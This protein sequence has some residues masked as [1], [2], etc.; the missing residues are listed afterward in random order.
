MIQEKIIDLLNSMTLDEKIGQLIQITPQLYYD[1]TS[2]TAETGPIEKLG[3]SEEHLYNIGSILNCGGAEKV[4]KVQDIFLSKNRLHIPLLFMADVINGFKTIFQ[5]PLLQGCSWDLNLIQKC[6][7]ISA[8]E[9]AFSGIQ[10]NFSPMVDLVRD[11]RWGRVLESTG[12]E[13]PYLGSIYAKTIVETYKSCGIASCVKH[14]AAYGASQSGRDYNTVDMSERE[15]REYYLPSYK[16]AIEANCDLVM[17]AFNILNGIPCSSNKYLMYDILRNELKFNGVVISDYSAIKETINHGYAKDSKDAALK[18]LNATVDIDMMSNVYYN[19]LKNLAFQDT[20]IEKLIDNAVL[21]VLTLKNNLGLFENPYGQLDI[22]KEKSYVMSSE[23]LEIARKTTA[24]TLVLL[25]NKNNILPLNN[26]SKIAL[27]GPYAENKGIS[28]IWSTIFYKEIEKTITLKEGIEKKVNVDNLQIARGCHILKTSEF[29]NLLS[30]IG[31]SCITIQNDDEME[32]QEFE[33]AI[34]VAKNSDIIILAIGEHYKQS[35]EGGSRSTIELPDIQLNLLNELYKLGKPIVAVLFSGRPL[36]VKNFVD[37]VSAL[38]WVG[39]PGI[40]GG[41]SI[42]DVLFGD[43]NPCGKLNMS[44]PQSTGQCPIYYNHYSTGRPHTYN[45][46]YAS[47]FLDI[48]TYSY[49]PF[50]YGLSYSNF[51]Y[52]NLVLSSD[53]ITENSTIDLSINVK[54]NSNVP[55]YEVVQLYIQDL[56]GSVVRPVKELKGFK[57]VFFNA[58]EEK[59]IS[60]SINNDMLKFYN[61]NL[62]FVS[63][64]GDFKVFVGSNSRD[65][66]WKVFSKID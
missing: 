4:K 38:L 6:A 64:A 50:G 42:A 54:N 44:F 28:G 30:S 35:G 41:N 60:F 10:V 40:Q 48:P 20:N 55:G 58:F 51:E 56:V 59:I 29:N 18:S 47:R 39:F 43:V 16:S 63:E 27:I 52:S 49:Y 66:L 31:E 46:R 1:D 3:I 57:K 5:I 24:N 25:E 21:R 9:A 53:I 26:N 23:N 7:E 19:N 13:D 22:E 37:K 34:N 12:G 45:T 17:T 33:K 15:F 2:S 14:F 61:H 32:R 65:N 62:K 8:K 36:A 11:S